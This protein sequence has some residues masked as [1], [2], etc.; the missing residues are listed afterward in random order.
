MKG[1]A[2]CCAALSCG[3]AAS[4]LGEPPAPIGMLVLTQTPR[5]AGSG[6]ARNGLDLG[7]PAGSRVVIAEAPW[8]APTVRVLSEGLYAAGG[9]VVSYDGERLYFAGRTG[10]ESEWQDLRSAYR[11]RSSAGGDFDAGGRCRSGV[12]PGWERGVCFACSWARPSRRHCSAAPTLCATARRPAPPAHL[13]E[14]GGGRSDGASGWQNP[15]CFGHTARPRGFAARPF[16]V[17]HQQ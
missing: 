1:W 17:Y 14:F 11:W 9:P 5:R 8:G 13:R 4:G 12:A 16:A 3:S 6:A 10:V 15:V 2:K 7:Y